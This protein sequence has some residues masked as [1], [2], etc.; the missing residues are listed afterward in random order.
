MSRGNLPQPTSSFV[1]RS[2]ELKTLESRFAQGQRLI[3]LLG[4]GGSGKT[5]LA[6]EFGRRH[7][8][9]Y[10]GGVWF[11]EL[12]PFR[13][14]HE[15]IEAARVQFKVNDL[16]GPALEAIAQTIEEDGA[17]LFIVDN[18]EHL[19]VEFAH[20]ISL[21][22]QLSPSTRV[23]AT[24]REPLHILGEFQV[25][26]GGIQPM[27]AVELFALRAASHVPDFTLDDVSKDAVLELANRVDY[28][29]LAIELAA[30]RV[31]LLSPASLVERLTH[32]MSALKSK[33]R[34]RPERHQT[35]AATIDWSWE[36]LPEH[37][38][39]TL[40]KLTPIRGTFS[41]SD[42]EALAGRDVLDTLAELLDSSMLERVG[43]NHFRILETVRGF[44]R[45]K[46]LESEQASSVFDAHARHFTELVFQVPRQNAMIL[47]RL[48]PNLQDI[49]TNPKVSPFLRAKASVAAGR[50]VHDSGSLGDVLN[51]LQN[52]ESQVDDSPEQQ[53]IFA[54]ALLLCSNFHYEQRTLKPASAFAQRAADIASACGSLVVEVLARSVLAL[55]TASTGDLAT[56]LKEMTAV[57]QK[58]KQTRDSHLPLSMRGNLAMLSFAAGDMTGGTALLAENLAEAEV[59]KAT[60]IRARTLTNLGVAAVAQGHASEARRYFM[61]AA[62]LLEEL[63]DLKFQA[64]ALASLA[65]LER[66][67]ENPVAAIPLYERAIEVCRACGL[68]HIEARA[69]A[70]RGSLY[71]D[72]A[73][74]GF[75]VKAMEI[76]EDES[77][78]LDSQLVR[79]M[80]FCFD[81]WFEND[82][83]ARHQARQILDI[84]S[85]PRAWKAVVAA[86]LGLSYAV[87]HD[88][89]AARTNLEKADQFSEL[90]FS[91]VFV[92]ACT[93]LTTSIQSPS[94]GAPTTALELVGRTEAGKL[95]TWPHHE[96]RRILKEL[97]RRYAPQSVRPLLRI[98]E[99]ARKFIPPGH[100][101]AVDFT[102]R[103]ALR[104]I[105]LGLAKA[106]Q[107]S[108]GEGVSLDDVLELG[109]PGERVTPEA[110]ASRVYTAIRTLRGFGLDEYLLTTDQGYLLSTDLDIA[111]QDI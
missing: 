43:D 42:A 72:A 106:R 56:A 81:L 84:E 98:T 20:A 22:M 29:P 78:S 77:D 31:N 2:H 18:L 82:P 87:R 4:P 92:A 83:L 91:N 61:D 57:F 50:V 66:H 34:D 37:Q 41:I 36:L 100:K 108:P 54:E 16:E 96:A 102:R 65:D 35:I 88:F 76:V 70:G 62:G 109:W 64:V 25:R 27:D 11:F 23:I 24:S 38:R 48:L 26:L 85:V 21:F 13:S 97:A 53:A 95:G 93:A 105:I 104:M 99:D 110:A 17:A 8:D 6:T 58:A 73:D 90:G 19:A 52:V 74:R 30:A 80:L 67:D 75:L 86:L 101:E 44:A 49:A 3:T 39:E 69:L 9:A 71:Q 28:L 12:T 40:L 79:S 33:D 32:R 89:D 55:C 5:R 45:T 68:S 10:P 51:L 94:L 14:A 60:R 15:A 7:R 103:G 107:D 46:L 59:L 47:K 1:G 111:F 63:G